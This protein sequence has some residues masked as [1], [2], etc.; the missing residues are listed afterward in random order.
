MT[1][2]TTSQAVQSEIESIKDALGNC[3]ELN[4]DFITRYCSQ[5][6]LE[7]LIRVDESDRESL[8]QESIT[9]AWA[10][11]SPASNSDGIWVDCGEIEVQ[12]ESEDDLEDPNEWTINGDCAYYYVGY[13]IS[14]A[15]NTDQLER[16]VNELLRN[17]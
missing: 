17:Q 9:H 10:N 4:D 2:L 6:V 11:G 14:F 3:L 1:K 7:Q 15:V 13:G 12:I 5:T 16:D 8:V